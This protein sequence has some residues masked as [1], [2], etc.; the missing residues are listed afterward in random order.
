MGGD[1]P[2]N[3]IVYYLIF[4]SLGLLGGGDDGDSPV[5]RTLD[6]EIVLVHFDSEESALSPMLECCYQ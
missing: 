2:E 5:A 6:K 1:L 4:L 3:D